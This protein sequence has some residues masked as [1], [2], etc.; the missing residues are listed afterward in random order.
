MEIRE[1][2]FY[3][4]GILAYVVAAS[5]GE[6]QQRERRE[7][8]EVIHDWSENIEVEFDVAEIIFSILTKSKH[9]D[10]LTYDRGLQYILKGKDYMTN[11]LKEKFVF[12]LQ[13]VAHAFPPVTEGEKAIVSRFEKDIKAI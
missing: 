1:Y 13:D 5:D 6:I 11:K 4:I 7:L 12:L 9:T 3:G 10:E 2:P 8:M